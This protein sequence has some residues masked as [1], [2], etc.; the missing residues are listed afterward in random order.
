MNRPPFI[1]ALAPPLI[2]AVH[3]VFEEFDEQL[4]KGK[5]LNPLLIDTLTKLT[6][7]LYNL[8]TKEGRFLSAW[9]KEELEDCIDAGANYIDLHDRSKKQNKKA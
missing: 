5:K 2:R 3:I 7:L 9:E 4:S 8:S 6:F 1:R